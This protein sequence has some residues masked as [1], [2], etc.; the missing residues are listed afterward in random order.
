MADFPTP[1]QSNN[2]GLVG[3]TG[4]S[5]GLGDEFMRLKRQFEAISAGKDAEAILKRF[6]GT[7]RDSGKTYDEVG[8]F[9]EKLKADELEL[10]K[11]RE[12]S[13]VQLGEFA[14]KIDPNNN[15]SMQQLM[16]L[17]LNEV[18]SKIGNIA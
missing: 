3:P 17:P 16:K 1:P 6:V 2:P 4:Q 9:L 5:V 13:A 14:K 11:V 7:L 12:K 18:P 10:L 8:K 15:M